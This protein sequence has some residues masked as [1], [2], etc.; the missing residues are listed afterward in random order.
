MAAEDPDTNSLIGTE[1]VAIGDVNGDGIL[2]I[3]TAAS[4][5]GGFTLYLGDGTGRNWTEVRDSGLPSAEHPEPGGADPGGWAR[6]VHLVDMN[7]DGR[8]DVVASYY[9]GPRVWRGDG[10]GHFEGHSKG[11]TTTS[12]GGVY[13]K[14]AVADINGDGRLD[15]AVANG[16]NGAEMYLQN[17]DGSWQGPIDMMPALKGGA[18]AIALGDLDGDGN[19]DVVIGG[20]LLAVPN[21]DAFGLYVRFGDGKG[22][23]VDARDTNLPAKAAQVVW[24]IKVVDVNGD[25][26]LDIVAGTGGA[27]GTAERSA[28]SPPSQAERAAA[29][30]ESPK[31]DGGKPQDDAKGGT[32]A[33]V[34]TLQVWVNEWTRGR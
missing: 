4:D 23:F 3:V 12:L 2:D 14:V 15:L 29:R 30:G 8:L 17:A 21:P 20:E 10:K 6:D 9:S 32:P 27:M 28:G 1:A 13:A 16:I 34:P 31:K 11:L 24:G 7:G 19:V 33:R 5:Q 26:R 25:G 18:Q 22:G